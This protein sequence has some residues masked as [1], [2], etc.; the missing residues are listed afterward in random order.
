MSKEDSGR[1]PAGHMLTKEERTWYAA[2]QTS[3]CL[4][5]LTQQSQEV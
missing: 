5:I 4:S 2:H 3:I 1:H